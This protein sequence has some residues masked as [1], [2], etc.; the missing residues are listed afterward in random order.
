MSVELRKAYIAHPHRTNL[1]FLLKAYQLAHRVFDRRGLILPVGLVQ[2]DIVRPQA[3]ETLFQFMADRLGA[4]EAIY[5][6]AELR[7]VRARRR[8]SCRSAV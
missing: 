6:L 8:G 3:P 4:E 2:I 7:P 5:L 1:P